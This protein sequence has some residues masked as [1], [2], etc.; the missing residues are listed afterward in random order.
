MADLKE[1]TVDQN[2]RKIPE[3]AKLYI[4]SVEGTAYGRPRGWY[5]THPGDL[6]VDYE[7]LVANKNRVFAAQRKG[8]SK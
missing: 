7:K 4:R 3:S 6:W 5:E 2:N 1:W 8:G